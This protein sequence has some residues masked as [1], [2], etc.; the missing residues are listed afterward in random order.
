MAPRRYVPVSVDRISRKRHLSVAL[1]PAT[2]ERVRRFVA[3]VQSHYHPTISADRIITQLLNEAL[4][5]RLFFAHPG[6]GNG[7][8]DR[9]DG[10]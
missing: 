10:F 5:A 3:K 9:L 4:D 8:A 2:I 7:R 6:S 1:D